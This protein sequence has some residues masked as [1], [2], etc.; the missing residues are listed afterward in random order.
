MFTF[1]TAAFAFLT[2]SLREDNRLKQTYFARGGLIC[3][4]L[5]MLLASQNT[6]GYLG[7][8]GLAFFSKVV[9]TNF[10]FITLTGL[11]YF[12]GAIAEEKEEGTL[13]LLRMTNLSPATILLGKSSSRLLGIALLLFV[14][15]PFTLLAVTLG[16]VSTH[17]VLAAYVSLGAY[18][19]FVCNLALL[20]SVVFERVGVA[21]AFTGL[22]LG[23]FFFTP[24]W[25]MAMLAALTSHFHVNPSSPAMLA[26]AWAMQKLTG[27]SVFMQLEQILTNGFAEPLF[28]FQVLSNLALGVFFFGLAWWGFDRFT[29]ERRPGAL[30]RK[31]PGWRVARFG[32]PGAGRAWPQAVWWKDFFLFH[33]GWNAMLLKVAG[34]A[35]LTWLI[36]HNVGRANRGAPGADRGLQVGASMLGTFALIFVVELAFG[37]GRIFRG[38]IQ[39][40]TLAGLVGLPTSVARMAYQKAGALLLSTLPALGYMA[41]GG[42]L[43][44]AN[45]RN[46]LVDHLFS[47]T[48]VVSLFSLGTQGLLFL[49][50]TAYLSLSLKRLSLAVAVVLI[51]VGDMMFA[52][53]GGLFFRYGGMTESVVTLYHCGLLALTAFLHVRV[54]HRLKQLAAA[55]G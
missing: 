44:L 29:R 41:V 30:A 14:Q 2:R 38:E 54:G 33:G 20:F 5:L 45:G 27:A 19:F 51:V 18:I 6:Y 37:A 21:S 3:F 46:N 1:D 32:M 48:S 36:N 52:A 55:E 53:L 8:P 9:M 43:V 31:L 34:F 42:V 24:L 12:A 28:G 26:F 11:S 22:T 10:F 40:K 39:G 13:G 23:L 7:A 17:Q 49:H 35:A 16:G 15:L 4:I 47:E 25:G 50:L